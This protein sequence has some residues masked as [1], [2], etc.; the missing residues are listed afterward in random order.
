M[1]RPS[2]GGSGTSHLLVMGQLLAVVSV[3]APALL[4][5]CTS[6]HISLCCTSNAMCQ[7]EP[8]VQVLSSTLTT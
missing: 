4:R 8:E 1:H 2:L 3:H 6:K 7:Y 5:W